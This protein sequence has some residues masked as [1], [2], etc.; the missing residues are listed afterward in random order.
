MTYKISTQYC[1]RNCI[2][3]ITSSLATAEF[4]VTLWLGGV[5]VMMLDR[6]VASS[7]PGWVVGLG[8]LLRW[9]ESAIR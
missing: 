7:T 9:T 6:K 5:T 3:C 4:L 2:A 1:N 8:L